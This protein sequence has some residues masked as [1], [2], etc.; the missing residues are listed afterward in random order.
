MKPKVCLDLDGVIVDFV[1]KAAALINMEEQKVRES[2]E[3]FD[4]KKHFQTSGF[5]FW[6][7][8]DER[9]PDFW[10]EMDFLPFGE[11]LIQKCLQLTSN[12]CFLTSPADSKHG[13]EGKHLWRD[14][15]FPDVPIIVTNEKHLHAS[16]NAILIDDFHKNTNKFR[17]HGG[18]SLLYNGYLAT[19]EIFEKLVEDLEGWVSCRCR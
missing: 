17:E 3:G 9:G 10:V 2:K 6:K 5:D 14:R 12:V 18:T 4:L 7:E 1:G 11:K 16:E 19:E 15:F 13:V 8:I